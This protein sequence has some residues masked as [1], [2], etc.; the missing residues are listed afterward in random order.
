M[1]DTD[2]F[3]KWSLELRG[4][5]E[6]VHESVRLNLPETSAILDRTDT[7][8]GAPSHSAAAEMQFRNITKH[9]QGVMAAH[10]KVLMSLGHDPVFYSR[11]ELA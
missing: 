1:I 4:A 7:L 5:A 6:G 3:D 2:A 10:D 11:Q 8:A 9:I